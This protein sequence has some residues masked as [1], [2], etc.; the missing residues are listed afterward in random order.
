[1]VGLQFF[2]YSTGM[3][4]RKHIPVLRFQ[5]SSGWLLLYFD[6]GSYEK[7]HSSSSLL[8]VNT[9]Y[10][11]VEEL[12]TLT[13]R[14]GFQAKVLMKS[15]NEKDLEI[16]QRRLTKTLDDKKIPFDSS[17]AFL[18]TSV[19]Q[20]EAVSSDLSTDAPYEPP[21]DPET[22]SVI[23]ES[24]ASILSE[25]ENSKRELTG[26]GSDEPTNL[27]ILQELQKIS[28]LLKDQ[29]VNHS[30][31]LKEMRSIRKRMQKPS[32]EAVADVAP[33]FFQ[34][35]DVASMGSKNL[36]PSQFGV[37]LA[38]FLF[39]DDDIE[40]KM[41]YPKRSSSRPPLSPSR[42]KV[43]KEAITNRFG[44]EAMD[45]AVR[46]VNSLGNDLKKGRRKRKLAE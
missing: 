5:N 32:I 43:F 4:K 30:A 18:D 35:V 6:D 25:N 46:A 23:N 10:D 39:T 38:R 15:S 20:S 41:L 27:L 29:C 37:F 26:S 3:E 36:D 13:L 21:V 42:S 1:M 34:D 7:I 44:R 28:K 22:E 16:Y 11:Q 45:E 8:P 40:K 17:F 14:P 24:I 19:N 9:K 12:S 33:V 31:I 2:S